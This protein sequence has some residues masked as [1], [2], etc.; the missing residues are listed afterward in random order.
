[1]TFTDIIILLVVGLILSGIILRMMR[2]KDQGVCTNCAYGKQCSKD[3]C[4]PKK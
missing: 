3:D 2:K 4:F 1:M